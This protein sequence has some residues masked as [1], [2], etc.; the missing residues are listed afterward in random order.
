MFGYEVKGKGLSGKSGAA[1]F[2]YSFNVN[3]QR[4][5]F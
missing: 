3:I 5:V 4:A 2:P 1:L